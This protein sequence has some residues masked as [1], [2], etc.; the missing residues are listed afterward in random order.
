MIVATLTGLTGLWKWR[1][2]TYFDLWC[3]I[4]VD[5]SSKNSCDAAVR[6]STGPLEKYQRNWV[7]VL[8]H[9]LGFGQS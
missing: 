9:S 3:L 8:K 6:N 5:S 4:Q 7:C 2:R 1:V